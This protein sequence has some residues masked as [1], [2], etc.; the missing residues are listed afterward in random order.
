[1]IDGA[2]SGARRHSLWD[3]SVPRLAARWENSAFR[4]IWE[5]GKL[6]KRG[7]GWVIR[8]GCHWKMWVVGRFAEDVGLYKV[9]VAWCW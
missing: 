6:I 4:F 5:N 2:W 7:G 9:N 8:D 3:V 1:M